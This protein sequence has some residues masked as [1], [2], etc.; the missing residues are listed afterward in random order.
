MKDT[1]IEE[2]FIGKIPIPV[3]IQGIETTLDQMKYYICK[4]YNGGAIGTGFF[5]SIPFPD[6]SNLLKVLI[7]NK[8][9]L[10][11]KE[12]KNKKEIKISLNDEKILKSI[13]IEDTRKIF[14]SKKYDVTFI[15]I[16][17]EKDDIV[18]FLEID[19]KIFEIQKYLE[20]FYNDMYSRNSIYILNHPEGKNVVVSYGT[21]KEIND[22]Y[23]HHYCSTKKGS[24][25][26]PILSLNNFSV[27]GIHC[28]SSE[29]FDYNKGIFIKYPIIEFYEEMKKEIKII[30]IK[31]NNQKKIGEVKL[32]NNNQP[33]IDQ[34]D[35]KIQNNNIYINS[36][37]ENNKNIKKGISKNNN[38]K[39]ENASME[40]K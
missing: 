16:I 4:I 34:K 19:D 6:K 14:S 21:L 5:C 26:S 23:I 9:V 12:I 32:N 40:N 24:S 38:E 39:K 37:F 10:N 7:T 1:I 22:T 15:E 20:D 13:K 31:I 33:N 8:H 18:N 3:T 35:K 27:I 29:K 36:E 25:G 28:G 2:K 11:E 17:E 30:D